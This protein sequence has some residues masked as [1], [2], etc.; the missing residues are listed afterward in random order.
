MPHLPP[1]L[2]PLHRRPNRTRT[3]LRSPLRRLLLRRRSPLRLRARAQPKS[4][5]ASR[6]VSTHRAVRTAA[7]ARLVPFSRARRAATPMSAVSRMCCRTARMHAACRQATSR[8]S[9]DAEI[10][11]RTDR[12]AAAA[13]RPSP[14]RRAAFAAHQAQAHAAR[15]RA[16]ARR[17]LLLAARR[18]SVCRTVTNFPHCPAAPPMH[19][20]RRRPLTPPRAKPTF[21]PS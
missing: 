9:R 21:R 14:R 12:A 13:R 8:A 1:P 11:P 15:A 17:P 6:S 20:R 7:A 19:Q 2:L 10:A 4:Q 3:A 5:R 16:A 18:S